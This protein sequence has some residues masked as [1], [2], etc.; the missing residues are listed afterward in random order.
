[1]EQ[2]TQPGRGP[3]QGRLSARQTSSL[4]LLCRD[5]GKLSALARGARRSR[6]RFGAA[7]ELFTVSSVQLRA[8]RSELW[9]LS[10]AETAT[11]FAHLARDVGALAH[12]SYGTE[13]VRELSPAEQP[14]PAVF[15]LLV[16]LF[17]ALSARGARADVLRAF[18]LSLLAAIGLAP[19]LESCAACGRD[20]GAG[21]LDRGAL[22][23]PGRGGAVCA[24]CAP[25]SRSAGVRP[26]SAGARRA[27]LSAQQR[28]RG[29]RSGRGRPRHGRGRDRGARRHARPDPPPRAADPCAR[30]SSWASS[31]GPR[32][33]ILRRM[34]ASLLERAR[35]RRAAL[36]VAAIVALGGAQPVSAQPEGGDKEKKEA[37]RRLAQG[38]RQLAR[39]DKLAERGK[40]EEAFTRFEAALAEYEAAY[41]AYPD[42]ADL[43]F[44]SRRPSSGW[45]AFSTRCSTTRSSW[46]SRR[47]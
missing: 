46:P 9:T 35:V 23:D 4:T 44:R 14:D 41:E 8:H 11:S 20:A 38:D 3:S 2:P 32:R 47:R 26:L 21:A 6:R 7:L 45:G 37:V 18:E 13:L 29:R 25:A 40:I 42:P 17:R 15:D 16:D 10:A 30:S 31:T 22:L 1:M 28:G 39:G 5:L 43:T 33:S 19:A 34:L 24:A 36:L 27:L 12:A